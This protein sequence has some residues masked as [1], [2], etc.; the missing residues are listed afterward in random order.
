MNS[1]SANALALC[2]LIQIMN[3]N[4]V[5]LILSVMLLLQSQNQFTAAAIRQIHDRRNR[6]DIILAM[7]LDSRRYKK[8]LGMVK[9]RSMWS[10]CSGQDPLMMPVRWAWCLPCAAPYSIRCIPYFRTL[11]G[12][13][14]TLNLVPR[15]LVRYSRSRGLHYPR[16]V[17][18]PYKPYSLPSRASC[19]PSESTSISLVIDT[20]LLYWFQKQV[21]IL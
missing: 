3:D 12:P 7:I 10:I 6:T 16:G 19:V 2:I 9:N 4:N 8:A 21:L 15:S 13:L 17:Q 14:R 18:L 11:R 5:F 20:C 1:R